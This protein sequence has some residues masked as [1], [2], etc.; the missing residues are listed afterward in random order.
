MTGEWRWRVEPVTAEETYPLRQQVLRPHQALDEV[1]F[2]GDHD[3][4][5]GHFAVF[6]G[7]RIVGVVTV[8]HQPPPGA[9]ETRVLAPGDW[10]R[11]RG[12]A[13]REECRH[14]GV[15]AALVSGV[16]DHVAARQGSALWCHARLPAVAFYRALGFA[17]AGEPWEE[18]AIG[19]HITMWW[20]LP[21]P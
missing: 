3:A 14:R 12:M 11:L 6:A 8:L 18:P 10:W 21:P 17:T 13:V 19:P 2:P 4:D 7:D 16:R 5:T 20:T 15:G 9:V 1:G